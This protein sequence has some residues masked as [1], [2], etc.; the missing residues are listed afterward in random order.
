MHI[1]L[2][3]E[4]VQLAPMLVVPKHT[5]ARGYLLGSTARTRG[6]CVPDHGSAVE[7]DSWALL[8]PWSQCETHT[9]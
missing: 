2:N 1:A 7:K 9:G 5:G 4:L 6:T 3:S 8:K